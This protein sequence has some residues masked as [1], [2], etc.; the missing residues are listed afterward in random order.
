MKSSGDVDVG[1]FGSAKV[2]EGSFYSIVGAE[3]LR[4]RVRRSAPGSNLS[5]AKR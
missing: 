5:N 3:L 4:I 1:S 2:R